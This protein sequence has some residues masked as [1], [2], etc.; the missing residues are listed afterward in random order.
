LITV[1][2]REKTLDLLVSGPLPGWLQALEALFTLIKN[3]VESQQYK[4]TLNSVFPPQ[5][6]PGSLADRL[7]IQG[8]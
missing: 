5:V 7:Y 2:L 8:P 3:N 4:Q 6:D 1:A